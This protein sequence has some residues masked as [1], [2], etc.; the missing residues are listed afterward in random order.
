MIWINQLRCIVGATPRRS[1]SSLGPNLTVA[2]T[3]R[4]VV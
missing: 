2:L 3:I 1:T 4:R